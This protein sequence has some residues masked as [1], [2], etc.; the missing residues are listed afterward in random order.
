MAQIQRLGGW[1]GSHGQ[2]SRVKLPLE[3]RSLDTGLRL[4]RHLREHR[5]PPS[6][7]L[8]ADGSQCHTWT[9]NSQM[10]ARHL[11]EVLSM[12]KKTL[13]MLK[14]KKEIQHSF[15]SLYKPTISMRWPDRVYFSMLLKHYGEP[16][17]F[18]LPNTLTLGPWS[19]VL[20]PSH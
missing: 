16:C 12:P 5:H 1:S 14:R 13:N 10:P 19:S 9:P 3:G 11:L 4:S 15:D 7:Y 6:V 8:D 20:L 18:T 2:G 17:H